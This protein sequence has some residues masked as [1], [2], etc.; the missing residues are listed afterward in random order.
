MAVLREAHHQ[1]RH[2]IREI[3]PIDLPSVKGLAIGRHEIPEISALGQFGNAGRHQLARF[4]LVMV[5]VPKALFVIRKRS[6]SFLAYDIFDADQ[7][8]SG[9]VRVEN[10][11]LVQI[12]P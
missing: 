12:V 10:Y 8:R 4:D 6:E 5:A 11:A 9:L 2:A 3:V 7:A 1:L